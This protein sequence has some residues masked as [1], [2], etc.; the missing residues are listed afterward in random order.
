METNKTYL[1]DLTSFEMFVDG[2]QWLW[3]SRI[4][5]M[6]CLETPPQTLLLDRI[7]ATLAPAGLDLHGILMADTAYGD[8][9]FFGG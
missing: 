3:Y 9:L 6:S 4:G 8:I 1:A 5:G 7:V 2:E